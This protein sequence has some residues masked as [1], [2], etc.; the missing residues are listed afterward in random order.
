M[1]QVAVSEKILNWA[2]ERSGKDFGFFEQKFPNIRKWL[3]GEKNPT[4][5]QLENFAKAVSTPFG[6]FFLSEPPIEQLSIPHFRTLKDDSVRQPSP[7]LLETVQ[8]ME[9]R[10]AW[11]REYLIDEGQEPFTFA[12][13]VSPDE[14]I[15]QIANNIRKTLGFKEEWASQQSTWTDALKVLRETIES[16]GIIVV[17]NGIVGNNTHRKLDPTEFRGFVLVDEYA[18]LVFVN[19]ADFKAAQMFT[20]AHEL[21]HI[22]FGSSAAFDLREIHPAD[23]PTEQAC[24]KVA[25]E[26]LVPE[27]K[28][29]QIW[30]SVQQ[31][32]EP[33]QTIARRFK[34]SEIVIARRALDL[35]LI[36]RDKFFD[37]YEQYQDRQDKE[38]QKKKKKPSSGDF[39]ANQN[40]RVGRGFADH[41]Y[42]AVKEGRL[43]YRDAYHLTG[44][45]GKTFAKYAEKLGY[46]GVL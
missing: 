20:L 14:D 25:A 3:K 29:H 17:V 5:R 31:D 43:L 35:R 23:D 41:V 4:F 33:F 7:D 24:N 6:Y 44:L 8:T 13:S 36:E 12:G 32:R 30:S 9:R 42:R 21:A 1:T 37:F 40:L 10:Q 39:Y 2:I 15:L 22:W 16:A 26:F 38:E 28:L 19:R 46:R 18:P 45:Y 11:L 34:V 27:A